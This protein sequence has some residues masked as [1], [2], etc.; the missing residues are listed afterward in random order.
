MGIT[1][2][3]VAYHTSMGD[4]DPCAMTMIDDDD[5]G[6]AF[7][8]SATGDDICMDVSATHVVVVV[9]AGSHHSRGM[10]Y[11]PNYLNRAA[12]CLSSSRFC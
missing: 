9:K 5:G 12:E 10:Y 3:G 4:D 1:Y 8:T 7:L 11:R 6:Y 2:R